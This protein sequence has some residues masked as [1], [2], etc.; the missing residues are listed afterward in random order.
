MSLDAKGLCAGAAQGPA[1]ASCLA[2]IRYM[3]AK[4]RHNDSNA[5]GV[6]RLEA[7]VAQ[8]VLAELGLQDRM[9][10]LR[11]W[12]VNAYYIQ[13]ACVSVLADLFP[14]CLI[15]TRA[16]VGLSLMRNNGVLEIV[17][18]LTSAESEAHA[19]V[20]CIQISVT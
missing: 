15:T 5:G 7:A 16:L 3:L 2:G 12:S 1:Q 10:V 18:T 17:I 19:V 4:G 9:L 20:R 8:V 6:A 14:C 13:T 11:M